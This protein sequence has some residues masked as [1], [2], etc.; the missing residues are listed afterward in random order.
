MMIIITVTIRTRIIV[1]TVSCL[2]PL[3]RGAERPNLQDVSY[4]LKFVCGMTLP[5]LFLIPER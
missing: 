1:R 2:L 3:C 4:Q 5:T